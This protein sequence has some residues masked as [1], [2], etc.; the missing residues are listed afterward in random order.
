MTKKQRQMLNA[1]L[2]AYCRDLDDAY[3]RY[4]H[5]K[6]RVYAWCESKR[7]RLNGYSPRIPSHNTFQFTYAFIFEKVN[8]KTGV[9]E[10][11][12]DYETAAHSY[13]FMLTDNPLRISTLWDL[14]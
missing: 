3:G 9:V 4:S 7:E 6:E 8:D 14:L 1:Y 2:N 10:I 5:E 12:M 13:E 11:W